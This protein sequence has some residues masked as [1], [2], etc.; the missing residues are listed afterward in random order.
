MDFL[1]N[2]KATDRPPPPTDIYGV[3]MKASAQIQPAGMDSVSWIV[4][5]RT[6]FPWEWLKD[7]AL[8]MLSLISPVPSPQ[9]QWQYEGHDLF[10]VFLF[11]FFFFF[12]DK[13]SSHDKGWS[14]SPKKRKKKRGG[15]FHTLP[16][17]LPYNRIFVSRSWS[18]GDVLPYWCITSRLSQMILLATRGRRRPAK[19]LDIPVSFYRPT[20]ITTPW[21]TNSTPT[22]VQLLGRYPTLSHLQSEEKER[23]PQWR[24]KI[25]KKVGHL[26]VLVSARDIA[27]HPHPLPAWA[28]TPSSGRQALPSSREARRELHWPGTGPLSWG[29]R[30]NFA[31]VYYHSS[32]CVC[33][34]NVPSRQREKNWGGG[35]VKASPTT[36]FGWDNTIPDR[37]ICTT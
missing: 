4:S 7:R 31:K 22:Y 1:A 35:H 14:V 6:P 12:C 5:R 10:F 24:I 27:L 18:R 34:C 16:P 3:G 8:A 15:A 20:I 11:L 30:S 21:V 17:P 9:H 25:K 29:E 13:I 33:V 32:V 2:W 37:A 36:S 28:R 23:K 26:P 19:Y